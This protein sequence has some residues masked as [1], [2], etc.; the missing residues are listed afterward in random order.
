MNELIWNPAAPNRIAT[1]T[2]YA[3]RVGTME[4]YNQ[5]DIQEWDIRSPYKPVVSYDV[6]DFGKLKKTLLHFFENV[7]TWYAH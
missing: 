4:K 7:C 2:I 1:A 3:T 5:L 6:E